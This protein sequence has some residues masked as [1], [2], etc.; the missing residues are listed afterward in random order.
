[1]KRVC[2]NNGLVNRKSARND[3]NSLT[4]TFA[5]FNYRG[6]C[7]VTTTDLFYSMFWLTTA[8]IDITKITDNNL[9]QVDLVGTVTCLS[10][11]AVLFS[12]LITI[13]DLNS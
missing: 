4:D 13:V 9:P 8:D 7:G 1:M 2:G 10:R 11:Y 12:K 6:R 3:N 5:K